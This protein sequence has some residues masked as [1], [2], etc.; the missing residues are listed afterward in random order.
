MVG[1]GQASV[2]TFVSGAAPATVAG[3]GCVFIDPDLPLSTLTVVGDEG[4]TIERVVVPEGD[5]EH[6]FRG[7]VTVEDTTGQPTPAIARVEIVNGTGWPG[8]ELVDGVPLDD[9]VFGLPAGIVTTSST[10][11]TQ[12]EGTSSTS[13]TTLVSGLP[14]CPPAPV[15]GC[16]TPQPRGTVLVARDR[17]N[18]ARDRLAWRVRRGAAATKDDFGDPLVATGF[19]LCLYDVTG[20]RMATDVPAGGRC[21]GRPCWKSTPVGYRFRNPSV[22]PGRV[23]TL[24]LAA[25]EDGAARLALEARGADLALGLPLAPPVTVQL[26]RTDAPGCWGA[27]YGA[28]R[29]NTATRLRATSD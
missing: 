19:R 23:R 6:V 9:F 29:K 16:G 18:D 14:A 17:R 2:V 13:T 24:R 1:G 8:A 25:G 7:I 15:S 10:T 26:T 22:V 28:A 5:G 3:F 11:T 27:R 20:L 21:G 12:G 4:G